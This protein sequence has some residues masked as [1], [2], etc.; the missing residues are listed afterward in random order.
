MKLEE[1]LVGPAPF[2]RRLA[3]VPFGLDHPI[4]IEDPEF[5]A[6]DHIHRMTAPAPDSEQALAALA[7]RIATQPLKLALE[8]RNSPSV[9]A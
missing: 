6:G 3:S 2:R 7:A 9:H 4:W 1:R 8:A 5:R